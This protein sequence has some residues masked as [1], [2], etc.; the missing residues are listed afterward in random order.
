MKEIQLT[1]SVYGED[2][3]ESLLE[4]DDIYKICGNEI[5][6]LNEC[7]EIYDENGSICDIILIWKV[8]HL[9]KK[10]NKEKKY[11]SEIKVTFQNKK[12]LVIMNLSNNISNFR[13]KKQ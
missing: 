8:L 3:L 9:D 6:I 12:Y 10:Q 7:E 4:I 5:T 2:S 13:I 11:P 1:S